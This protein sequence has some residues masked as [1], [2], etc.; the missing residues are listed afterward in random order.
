[1]AFGPNQL[2]AIHLVTEIMPL[3]WAKRPDATVTL[4][5]RDPSAEILALRSDRVESHGVGSRRASLCAGSGGFRV[6]SA[7]GGRDQD[8]LLQ[9]WAMG[10]AIVA[11]S[12]SVGGL[13]ARDGEN[14][15]VR[16]G[17]ESF[18]TAVLALL[19]DRSYRSSLGAAGRET[20]ER[21]SSWTAQA[22]NFAH[23]LTK[24]QVADIRE[25]SYLAN[26]EERS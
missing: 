13:A 15:L 10:K 19:Q 9:A 24:V 18:S 11:T 20:V 22:A 23:I 14:I 26:A 1:M 6:S 21:D 12:F 8:E 16:D 4:V 7:V 17:A 3:V 5:G 25:W 2:A